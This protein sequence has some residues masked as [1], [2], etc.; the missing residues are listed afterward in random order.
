MSGLQKIAEAVLPVSVVGFMAG[1]LLAIGLETNLRAALAPLT[2]KQ[3][4]R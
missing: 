3:S 2:D 4:W 1:N